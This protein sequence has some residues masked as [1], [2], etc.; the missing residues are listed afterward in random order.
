MPPEQVGLPS[1]GP[2]LVETLAASV[3][4]GP[5]TAAESETSASIDSALTRDG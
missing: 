2:R 4:V 3:S 1:L 5:G